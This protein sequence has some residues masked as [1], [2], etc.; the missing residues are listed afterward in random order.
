MKLQRPVHI[1]LDRSRF[2]LRAKARAEGRGL[3]YSA[4]PFER[5]THE[6]NYNN[7][8]NKYTNVNNFYGQ[9]KIAQHG[10][11]SEVD[12]DSHARPRIA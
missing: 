10:T 12:F 2:G 5:N 6:E 7:D 3:Q 11:S 4:T 8:N 9:K 1:E